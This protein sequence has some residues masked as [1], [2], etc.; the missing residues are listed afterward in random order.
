LYGKEQREISSKHL[1]LCCTKDTIHT[2]GAHADGKNKV[3]A[4]HIKNI[5]TIYSCIPLGKM[6]LWINWIK[7]RKQISTT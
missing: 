6:C 4:T 2:Y 3:T 7:T 1:L 5:C